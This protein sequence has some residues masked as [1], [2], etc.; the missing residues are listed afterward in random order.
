[1]PV[2]FWLLSA[3]LAMLPDADVIAFYFGIPYGSRFGHR[4]FTHSLFCAALVG[5]LVATVVGGEFGFPWWMMGYFSPWRPIQVCL[6]GA[7]FLHP[8]NL[9][10]FR[11]ELVW[12]W[13][14]LVLVLGGIEWGRT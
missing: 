14:P 8:W 11:S 3:G 10:A 13:L 9:R 12:V 2:S 5:M 6:I 4:G 1:M 7:Q